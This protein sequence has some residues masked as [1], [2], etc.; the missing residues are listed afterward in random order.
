MQ[1]G[2]LAQGGVK[3]ILRNT[4][5]LQQGTFSLARIDASCRGPSQLPACRDW[6]L[7]MNSK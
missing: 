2:S 3:V 5:W 7:G 6:S 4:L 1:R